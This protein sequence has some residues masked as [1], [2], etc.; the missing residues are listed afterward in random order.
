MR[1]TKR[2][3]FL[4]FTT[5]SLIFSSCMKDDQVDPRVLDVTFGVPVVQTKAVTSITQGSAVCGG[6]VVSNSGDPVLAYGVCWSRLPEPTIK[7]Y[8]TNNG[9]GNGNYTSTLSNLQVGTTYYV[10]AFAKNSNGVGYGK[11][12]SFTTDSILQ[13][14]GEYQGGLV[15]YIDPSGLH[16]LICSKTDLSTSAVWGCADTTIAGADGTAIGTGSNNSL[17]ILNGCHTSGIAAELCL[18]ANI[19]DYT[20]WFLPSKEELKLMYA[21][22]H[23]E[24][25]GNFL[26]QAY[27]SS[28]EM[29]NVFAW[30]LAFNSGIVQGATKA[31][32]SGVRAIRAF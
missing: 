19:E 30:Q 8:I 13:L 11:E 1:I 32:P 18:N 12:L 17:D 14:G 15:F 22:L 7:D 10:R 2:I 24:H 5:V 23:Q 28:T 4:L 27:W 9:G 20:D 21:N 16:G 31:L 25:L 29:T 26:N 3:S 6:K